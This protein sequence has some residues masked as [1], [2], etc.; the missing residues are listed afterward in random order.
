VLPSLPDPVQPLPPRFPAKRWAAVVVG[1]AL[2]AFSLVRCGVAPPSGVHPWG[3]FSTQRTLLGDSCRA[4]DGGCFSADS[5]INVTLGSLLDGGGVV[6]FRDPAPPA[7]GRQ[8]GDRFEIVIDT[9]HGGLTQTTC[10]CPAT[11]VETI[12]G[13]FSTADGGSPPG[14]SGETGLGDAGD[15]DAGT[16][17]STDGGIDAG[18]STDLD[19]GASPAEVCGY[20]DPV[21]SPGEAWFAGLDGGADITRS[22]ASFHG[23]VVDEI[24]LAPGATVPDGGCPCLPCKVVYDLAGSH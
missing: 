20:L 5:L 18:A 6:L 11:V 4:V 21:T 16:P 17:A 2:T 13:E 10:G 15:L 9:S 3:T 24:T 14:R 23:T 8:A 1:S 7:M 19:A 22:Y 12:W